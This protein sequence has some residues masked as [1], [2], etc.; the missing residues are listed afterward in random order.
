MIIFERYFICY[1]FRSP[2]ILSERELLIFAIPFDG[3]NKI[4]FCEGFGVKQNPFFKELPLNGTKGETMIIKAPEL[5][6]DF[7]IKSTVFVLPLGDDLYKVGATFNWKD[8][9]S[10]PTKEGKEGWEDMLPEGIPEI[11]KQKRLFGFSRR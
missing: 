7:Q 3:I 11:I 4:V 1:I 6:I 10:K 2:E 9:T 8:K 5:Q